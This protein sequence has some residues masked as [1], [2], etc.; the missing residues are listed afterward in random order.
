M[1]RASWRSGA[2]R[3]LPYLVVAGAGFVGAYLIVYFFI[4]PTRLVPNDRPVPNVVGMLQIDAE[5]ALRE[6]GFEP[7]QGE[8]R[9]NASVPPETVLS[10]NPPATTLKPAKTVVTLDIATSP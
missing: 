1:T 5:R 3:V 2:R 9:V 6:S 4:F 8:R 7:Q 10:Q